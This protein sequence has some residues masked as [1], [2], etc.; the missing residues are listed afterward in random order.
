MHAAGSMRIVDHSFVS[1]SSCQH[2]HC[3]LQVSLEYKD[4]PN[5]R[6]VGMKL[7]YQSEPKIAFLVVG[8][9]RRCGDAMHDR[10][11]CM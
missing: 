9:F 4:L 2:R 10:T 3:H 1:I 6:Y 11:A 7:R 8:C 5:A